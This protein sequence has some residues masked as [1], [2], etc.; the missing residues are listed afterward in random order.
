MSVSPFGLSVFHLLW[1]QS[2]VKDFHNISAITIVLFIT[3][4]VNTAKNARSSI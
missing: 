1:Q 4:L 3:M 2:L